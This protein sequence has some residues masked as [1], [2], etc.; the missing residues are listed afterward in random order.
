MNFQPKTEKEIADGKLLPR[1]EYDFEIAD[2]WEKKSAAGN[3][4]IELKVQVSNDKGLSRTLSDYLLEKRA[5]KL[6]NCSNACGLLDK[7]ES[8][9][10][11]NDDFV[12]KR[13]RLKLGVEKD[14]AGKYPPKNIIVDYLC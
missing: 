5:G 3:E 7:Y 12:G 9:L 8:G 1:G 10:L 14:R 2:A 4:M 6:R 13:G 11:S